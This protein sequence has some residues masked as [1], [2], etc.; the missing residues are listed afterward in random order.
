MDRNNKNLYGIYAFQ[1]RELETNQDLTPG[2]FIDLWTSLNSSWRRSTLVRPQLAY[3]F[4]DVPKCFPK[5]LK[6]M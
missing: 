3:I 6:E 2:S 1:E 4:M 5:C